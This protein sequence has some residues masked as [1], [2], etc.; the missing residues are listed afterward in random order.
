MFPECPR[1]SGGDIAWARFRSSSFTSLMHMCVPQIPSSLPMV[2]PQNVETW[3]HDDP[4]V[5]ASPLYLRCCT[6]CLFF[7]VLSSCSSSDDDDDV[8]VT[9]AVKVMD[10][11]NESLKEM[12]GSS[13]SALAGLQRV[14]FASVFGFW[15][16]LPPPPHSLVFSYE[17]RARE[18]FLDYA[19]GKRVCPFLYCS[20]PSRQPPPCSCSLE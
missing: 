1:F 11:E 19:E 6:P 8:G 7:D 2:P 4:R 14:S 9:T 15:S 16:A 13:G 10:D 20:L 12:L 17:A 3:V 18:G 5:L